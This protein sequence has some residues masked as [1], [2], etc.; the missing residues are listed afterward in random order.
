MHLLLLTSVSTPPKSNLCDKASLTRLAAKIRLCHPHRSE[1]S[2]ILAE[3][4]QPQS[5]LSPIRTLGYLPARRR[6][7]FFFTFP[8]MWAGTTCWAHGS[9]MELLSEPNLTLFMKIKQD[10]VVTA[11]QIPHFERLPMQVKWL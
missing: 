3:S 5:V 7:E 1:Q 11:A 10:I 4:P 6:G 9:D 8:G 2:E